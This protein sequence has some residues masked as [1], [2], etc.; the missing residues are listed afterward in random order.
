MEQM[1]KTILRKIEINKVNL[2]NILVG[3]KIDPIEMKEF[4]NAISNEQTILGYELNSN[5]TQKYE[6]DKRIIFLEL[7]IL[8]HKA[9]NKILSVIYKF[10]KQEPRIIL[11]NKK[12]TTFWIAFNRDFLVNEVAKAVISKRIFI[13]QPITSKKLWKRM[14]DWNQVDL[15]S[16]NEVFDQIVRIIYHFNLQVETKKDFKSFQKTYDWNYFQDKSK[17]NLLEKQKNKLIKEKNKSYNNNEKLS[18][19]LKLKEIEQQIN[20]L[21]KQIKEK[22]KFFKS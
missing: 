9:I 14:L 10:L 16:I 11:L 4:L 19:S 21:K 8:N 5:K 15:T 3:T 18:L 17:I 20:E 2:Q 1:K 22:E 13:S 7:E 6:K 12:Q